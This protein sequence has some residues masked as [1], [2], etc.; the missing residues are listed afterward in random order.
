MLPDAAGVCLKN[1]FCQL[2][3]HFQLLGLLMSKMI[4]KKA[5][6]ADFQKNLNIFRHGLITQ[7]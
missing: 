1:H 7:C 3:T 2:H 4:R 5:V 6:A